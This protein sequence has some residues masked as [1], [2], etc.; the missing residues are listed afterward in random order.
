MQALPG[1][2]EPTERVFFSMNNICEVE[3]CQTA[4]QNRNF[5][6]WRRFW[7]PQKHQRAVLCLPEL[8]WTHQIQQ[9]IVEKKALSGA[10][11]METQ[12]MG[13]AIQHRPRP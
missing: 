13:Q 3:W 8:S 6:G 11:E 2:N 5:W 9:S 12:R 10:R 1:A 7:S 4:S